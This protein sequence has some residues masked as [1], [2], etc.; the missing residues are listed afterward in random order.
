MNNIYSNND[1]ILNEYELK[2]IPFAYYALYIY[3]FSFLIILLLFYKL[4]WNTFIMIKKFKNDIDNIN[5]TFLDL[6]NIINYFNEN[7]EKINKIKNENKINNSD[8]NNNSD[9][10]NNNLD[11]VNNKEINKIIKIIDMIN[12]NNEENKNVSSH[13]DIIELD[14]PNKINDLDDKELYD[15]FKDE[16]S[17]TYVVGTLEDIFE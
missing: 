7:I 13:F 6:L 10:V 11:K 2:E 9:N 4:L 15:S 17:P 3:N 5:I 1:W 16:K 14:N 12:Y 8:N